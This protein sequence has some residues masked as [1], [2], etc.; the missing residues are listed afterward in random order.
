MRSSRRVT[1]VRLA[2]RG[3]LAACCACLLMGSCHKECHCYGYDGAHTFYTEE[4]VDESGSTC[5]EM[6]YF[7]N[8]RRF[9]LCEWDY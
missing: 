8:V 6:I 1:S 5:S 9:S 3:L 4:Q 2:G 7:A